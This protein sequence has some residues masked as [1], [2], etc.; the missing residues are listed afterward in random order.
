M[1]LHSESNM[2]AAPRRAAAGAGREQ[3][4]RSPQE[5]ADQQRRGGPCKEAS[6]R[7]A[8]Q[9]RAL[10]L[11]RGARHGGRQGRGGGAQ[12]QKRELGGDLRQ[13]ARR[14]RSAEPEQRRRERDRGEQPRQR[15]RI[16][17]ARLGAGGEDHAGE[18]REPAEAGGELQ[19]EGPQAADREGDRAQ[20]AAERRA[21]G[22]AVQGERPG[23]ARRAPI[24]QGGYAQGRQ[25]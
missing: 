15:D 10:H 4:G 13:Q 5:A 22:V 17:R 21:G 16:G 24:A 14:E 8:R 9:Q 7:Q 12:R 23:G 11:P 1:R 3:R 25:K 2:G 19:R 18:R 6:R 20:L